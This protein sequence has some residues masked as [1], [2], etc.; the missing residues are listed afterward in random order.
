MHI[1]N[2][3]A[4]TYFQKTCYGQESIDYLLGDQERCTR[5]PGQDEIVVLNSG[6]QLLSGCLVVF[7]LQLANLIGL[8]VREG[9]RAEIYNAHCKYNRGNVLMVNLE[10]KVQESINYSLG[11]QVRCTR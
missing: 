7:L 8:A 10:K 5:C 6:S 11:D 4:R 3:T 9:S 2:E 1:V